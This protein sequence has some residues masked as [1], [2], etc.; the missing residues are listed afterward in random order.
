MHNHEPDGYNCPFCK[1]VSGSLSNDPDVIYE[2]ELGFVCLGLRHHENSGPTVL[3]VPKAYYENIYDLPNEVLA[4]LAV[5]SK[6]VAIAV[7]QMP[8]VEGVTVWQNN[9][10]CGTQDVWHYHV[11]VKGR[12]A[13]DNVYKASPILTPECTKVEWTTILTQLLENVE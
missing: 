1:M 3:V 4:H 6:N 8:G 11:H 12:I 10:P 9:E 5:L 2:S 7:R 13:G